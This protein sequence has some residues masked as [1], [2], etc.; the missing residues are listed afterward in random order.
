ME[1]CLYF[2][3]RK[4]SV[5]SKVFTPH[6]NLQPTPGADPYILMKMSCTDRR[7]SYSIGH[8][9]PKK[10]WDNKKEQAHVKK[11]PNPSTINNRISEIQDWI[12]E[13]TEGRGTVI[14]NELIEFLKL[15]DGRILGQRT[16]ATNF[17][18]VIE[19]RIKAVERGEIMNDGKPF[20]DFTVKNWRSSLAKMK[21]FNPYLT[22]DDNSEAVR[23]SF[24][25]WSTRQGYSLCYA[26]RII[27]DWKKFFKLAGR[28]L[29][30]VRLK[31]KEIKS[32][33]VDVYLT[34]EDIDKLLNLELSGSDELIRDRYVFNHQTG[35]RISD[36]KHITSE[37]ID[38]NNGTV[39]YA[40]TQKT[41]ADA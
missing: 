36:F 17:F 23:N 37:N 7:V 39:D 40:N 33:R 18:D 1:F 31:N 25:A 35:F 15:K 6:F 4:F 14:G 30:F 3:L 38:L 12:G 5:M 28:K 2:C 32:G 41:G 22:F 21:E 9:I 13:F 34:D 24:L 16:R 26:D 20:S 29:E 10:F 8:S 19:D 27:K 11:H